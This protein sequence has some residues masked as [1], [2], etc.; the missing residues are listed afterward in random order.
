M[1]REGYP[2]S[3][4]SGKFGLRMSPSFAATLVSSLVI[5]CLQPMT[6]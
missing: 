6:I 3:A 1:T 4:V 5:F 2:I